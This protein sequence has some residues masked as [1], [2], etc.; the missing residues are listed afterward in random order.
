MANPQSYWQNPVRCFC[1][2]I[3][4]EYYRWCQDGAIKAL[5]IEE[6]ANLVRTSQR[7][8]KGKPCA[9]ITLKK[10]LLDILVINVL[11]HACLGRK[12]FVFLISIS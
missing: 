5:F 1:Q 8:R 4:G 7:Q 2:A 9:A 12:T 3:L 6:E 11:V 10:Y